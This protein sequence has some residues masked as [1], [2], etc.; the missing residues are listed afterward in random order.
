EVTIEKG[1]LPHSIIHRGGVTHNEETHLLSI[2]RHLLKQLSVCADLY[3][4][5]VR[6]TPETLDVE[7]HPLY[8]GLVL[9]GGRFDGIDILYT[10]QCF[11]VGCD[12]LFCSNIRRQARF[13]CGCMGIAVDV[14]VLEFPKPLES[15]CHLRG[16]AYK[17]NV[18][19]IRM[20]QFLC[21]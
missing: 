3:G 14:K 20:D 11:Y 10:S 19:A 5:L 6:C 16:F 8:C 1:L 18:G 2:A 17:D 13:V 7:L 15:G 9:C 21:Y 12:H 4:Q